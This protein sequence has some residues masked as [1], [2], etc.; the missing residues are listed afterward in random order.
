MVGNGHK[1]IHLRVS[2]KQFRLL[3][4]KVAERH[5]VHTTHAVGVILRHVTCVIQ[6]AHVSTYTLVRTR[7]PPT[8]PPTQ[9]PN[10][11][12]GLTEPNKRVFLKCGSSMGATTGKLQNLH[13]M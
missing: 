8:A 4:Y 7:A 9:T 5:T 13:N 11:Q 10:Y 1:S 2:T 12:R 3:T 6:K